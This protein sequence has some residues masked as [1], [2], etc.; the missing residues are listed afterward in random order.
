[1]GDS[2]PQYLAIGGNLIHFKRGLDKFPE[3]RSINGYQP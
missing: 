3:D 2:L 1:M